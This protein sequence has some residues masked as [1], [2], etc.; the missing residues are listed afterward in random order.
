MKEKPS[1]WVAISDL[2]SGVMAVVMLLLVVSVL[3]KSVSDEKQ[4]IEGSKGYEGKRNAAVKT[5]QGIKTDLKKKGDSDIISF[6]MGKLKMTLPDKLFS[7]SSACIPTSERVKFV[8]VSESIRNLLENNLEVEIYV[9]GHTDNIVVSKPVLDIVQYCTVYD[10]N[11][12][13]SA[14]RAR[15]VRKLIAGGLPINLSKRVIVAGYGD[16]RPLPGVPLDS[17]S[18]RRVEIRLSIE[19]NDSQ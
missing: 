13:L 19:K 9:D 3:Q 16:S 11:Y 1:E 8:P 2:M 14:A 5:L 18:N 12:T 10:D 7:R 15:E 4:K 17:D 6:D